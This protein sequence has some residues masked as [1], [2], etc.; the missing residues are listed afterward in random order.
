M[1]WIDPAGK[2]RKSRSEAF[3]TS[4]QAENWPGVSACLKRYRHPRPPAGLERAVRAAI[5][6]G[7]QNGG[8]QFPV[9]QPRCT[10]LVARTPT[11]PVA[12]VAD[13]HEVLSAGRVRS[14][15]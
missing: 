7:Q 10:A 9:P 4:G 15:K 11:R 3:G 2:K 12:N 6:M 8:V 13:Q 5:R 14:V 1:R